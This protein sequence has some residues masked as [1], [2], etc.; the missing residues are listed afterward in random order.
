MSCGESL[1]LVKPPFSSL[2]ADDKTSSQ[3]IGGSY[4]LDRRAVGGR[5]ERRSET[6]SV[7]LVAILAAVEC[8]A[9]P[10]SR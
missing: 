8:L 10:S 4:F 3:S 9:R 7:D 2:T 5:Q 1:E 6:I